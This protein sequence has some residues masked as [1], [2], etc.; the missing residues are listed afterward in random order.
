[1][2]TLTFHCGGCDATAP[3]TRHLTRHFRSLNG[4]GWGFGTYEYEDARAVCPEG[5]IA[6]DLIGATYCP[7]CTAEIFPEGGNGEIRV[8]IGASQ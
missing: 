6:Y 4:Q 7:K 2:I 8:E 5:W 1:M 3:G